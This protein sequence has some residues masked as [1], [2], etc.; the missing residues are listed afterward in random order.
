[1]QK[2]ISL[3]KEISCFYRISIDKVVKSGVKWFKIEGNYLINKS[4]S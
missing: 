2:N 3:K 4:R 1:M